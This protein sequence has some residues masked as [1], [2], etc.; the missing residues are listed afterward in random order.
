[1]WTQTWHL[2]KLRQIDRETRK[3]IIENSG[4]HPTNLSALLYLPRSTDA[5]VEVKDRLSCME[6]KL[7]KIKA[8]LKVY[9][10]PV[11]SFISLF[12]RV[13][14]G[15]IFAFGNVRLSWTWNPSLQKKYI[16]EKNQIVSG[17]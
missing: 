5:T 13:K 16:L 9:E 15:N 1:M 4:R 17:S 10:N 2:A 6:Y 12:F 7:I 8:A 14:T 3:I 11:F